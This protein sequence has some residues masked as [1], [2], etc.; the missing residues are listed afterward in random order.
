MDSLAFEIQACFSMFGYMYVQPRT[1]FE[2]RIHTYIHTYLAPVS[3][4]S[5]ETFYDLMPHL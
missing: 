2:T 3:E 1:E 4:K 5:F